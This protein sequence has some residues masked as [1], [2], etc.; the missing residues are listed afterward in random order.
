MIKTL[1][2]TQNYQ[3]FNW[4]SLILDIHYTH[5]NNVIDILDIHLILMR[6]VTLHEQL[7]NNQNNTTRINIKNDK[8]KVLSRNEHNGFIL[9]HTGKT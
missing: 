6:F 5:T 7:D 4:Y 2:T 9:I 8:L 1:N 3:D